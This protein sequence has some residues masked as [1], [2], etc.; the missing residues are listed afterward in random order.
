MASKLPLQKNPVRIPIGKSI[1]SP[2]GLSENYLRPAGI[3]I[4]KS[5]GHGA[6][7]STV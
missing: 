7:F 5:I 1:E 4:G 6:R 3:P 2:I